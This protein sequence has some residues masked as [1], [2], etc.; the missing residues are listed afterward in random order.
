MSHQD[1]VFCGAHGCALKYCCLEKQCISG[2][3]KITKIFFN[4]DERNEELEI[5]N[6]LNL[7]SL[8]GNE[9]MQYFIGD[10]DTCEIDI[11]QI[12]NPEI[13]LKKISN[14]L[15]IAKK[16][17]I[18]EEDLNDKYKVF[19]GISYTDG[20]FSLIK[21]VSS[22][23]NIREYNILLNYL[24]NVFEGI[25]IL[26][27]N[28]IYHLDLK[29]DNIVIG[30]VNNINTC[31][32]IDFGDSFQ[33]KFT[34]EYKSKSKISGE[35]QKKLYKN[36][37]T[38]L[39]ERLNNKDRIGTLEYM[40]PEMYILSHKTLRQELGKNKT[41]N[42]NSLRSTFIEG[43]ISNI[44][45]ENIEPAAAYSTDIKNYI[46]KILQIDFLTEQTKYENIIDGIKTYYTQILTPET[47]RI[48]YIKS[49][50]WSLGIILVFIYSQIKKINYEPE[51]QDQ[52]ELILKNLKD[53]I[54]KLL[55]I[56]PKDRP[57]AENSL[58]LYEDFLLNIEIKKTLADKRIKG[59]YKSKNNKTKHNKSKHSKS[60]HS[61]SK[62]NKSKH[63]KSKHNKS[64]H[65]KTKDKDNNNN[66]KYYKI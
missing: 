8:K 60:K 18:T 33:S 36:N 34:K 17:T 12:P 28:G 4:T 35:E 27:H 26:H 6:K 19:N 55:I 13:N 29:P 20:G 21:Y 52:K 57:D 32:L 66:K 39:S 62:H 50:I 43:K 47:V 42:V 41:N 9:T 48:K 46:E 61:K 16:L 15:S 2:I 58:K 1:T 56:N 3:N 30:T 5:Y 14:K 59:G 63:N 45:N 31:R 65:N 54:V 22:L 64:K 23:K 37:R 38:K 11:T 44:E 49:D 24:K 40:S 53:L 10:A 25:Q 7:N 51:K